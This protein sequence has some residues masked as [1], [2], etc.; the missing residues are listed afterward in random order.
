[1]LSGLQ[2]SKTNP[3]FEANLR[4]RISEMFCSVI[5]KPTFENERKI[6]EPE[7]KRHYD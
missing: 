5:F 6:F 7:K 3:D 2:E 4:L 1:M